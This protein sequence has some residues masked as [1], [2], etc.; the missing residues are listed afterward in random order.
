MSNLLD[1]KVKYLEELKINGYAERTIVEYERYIRY[2]IEY[3]EKSEVR[4]IE[5]VTEEDLKEY[6]KYRYYYQNMFGRQ[7][8]I[9]MQN[10]H[11]S[12]IKFFFNYL[13][14]ENYIRYNPAKVLE[15]IKDKRRLPKPAL[16]DEEMKKLLSCPD[17]TISIG[18]RDRTILEVLYTTGMRNNE[19][20]NL[21]VED[22]YLQEGLIRINQGKGG[23]D[24]I[25]P[26]GKISIK[27]LENYIRFIR[28][29]LLKSKENK[30]L[31]LTTKGAKFIKERL[32]ATVKKY[33]KMSKIK[34]E[35]TP[36]TFRRSCATEM[37][38]NKVNIMYVKEILGH[39]CLESIKPYC[40]LSIIDL[41]AAH[42]KFHPRENG[43]V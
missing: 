18:Y 7:D 29:E 13:E 41:K 35:I 22:V 40:K 23:K 24:R 21:K 37:I 38:K 39:E 5:E 3:L 26:I 4:D 42:D 12:G 15:G 19:L 14:R 9:N 31:F 25:V 8:T 43:V 28:K 36:H 6:K 20:C 11:I 1:Y 10:K 17:T 33:A 30:Y 27:Y 32:L 34:K 16:T 2:L